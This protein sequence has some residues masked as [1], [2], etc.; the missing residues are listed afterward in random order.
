MPITWKKLQKKS[1]NHLAEIEQKKID[2]LIKTASEIIA[3][4]TMQET[5]ERSKIH[6]FN[7]AREIKRNKIRNGKSKYQKEQKPLTLLGA[8]GIILVGSG[9]LGGISFHNVHQMG[10][11]IFNH[12]PNFNF[13]DHSFLLCYELT[14]VRCHNL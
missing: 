7:K 3:E 13:F 6:A 4:K 2:N 14:E 8:C 5:L 10:T 1:K 9:Y 11:V 12:C